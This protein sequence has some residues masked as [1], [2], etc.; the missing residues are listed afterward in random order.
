[1]MEEKLAR[2]LEAATRAACMRVLKEVGDLRTRVTKVYIERDIP[3]GTVEIT[4]RFREL[5]EGETT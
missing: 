3:H 2:R 5:A 1:M 4:L